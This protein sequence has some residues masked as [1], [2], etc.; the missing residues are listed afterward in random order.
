MRPGIA[1]LSTCVALLMIGSTSMAEEPHAGHGV[2][3]SFPKACRS[4][5]AP[6]AEMGAHDATPM[7]EPHQADAMQGMARMDRDMMQGMMKDDPDVAFVCGM[8]AHHQGAIDMARVELE[9]GDDPWAKAM[10]QKV[11]DAQTRE[12][13]DM[14]EWLSHGMA[15]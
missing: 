3:G 9:H 7:T 14:T 15:R 13:A 4:D 1:A 10:A 2:E 6:M 12:I 11:I 5:L 8:I